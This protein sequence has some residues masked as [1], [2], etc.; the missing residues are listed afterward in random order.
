MSVRIHVER[1]QGAGVCVLHA[2]EVFDQDLK[3][4][5]VV[6]KITDPPDHLRQAVLDAADLCPNAVVEYS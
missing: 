2:P 4:G 3:D 6:V 1:C 5:T